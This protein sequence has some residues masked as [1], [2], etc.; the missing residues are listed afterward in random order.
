M[1][2]GGRTRPLTGCPPLPAQLTQVTKGLC[3]KSSRSSETV[4]SMS[5]SPAGSGGRLGE[6][7]QLTQETKALSPWPAAP[8][9]AGRCLQGKQCAAHRS[10]APRRGE[11][12]DRPPPLRSLLPAATGCSSPAELA[13]QLQEGR[14]GQE[15]AAPRE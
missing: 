4:T 12:Q 6:R 1:G 5:P 9:P 7:V 10:P 13:P 2:D 3:R 11:T 14:P 15:R 8:L